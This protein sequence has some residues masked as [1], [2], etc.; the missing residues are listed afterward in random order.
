MQLGA[1]GSFG[2]LQNPQNL[3]NNEILNSIFQ[4]PTKNIKRQRFSKLPQIFE[5]R[6]EFEGL[7]LQGSKV[8]GEKTKRDREGA[9]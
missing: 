3:K 6:F 2:K 9:R 8:F 7:D 1:W 5:L 4:E